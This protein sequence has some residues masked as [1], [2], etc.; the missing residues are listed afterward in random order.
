M[1]G[2]V[3]KCSNIYPDKSGEAL[4]SPVEYESIWALGVK[5]SSAIKEER[6]HNPFCQRLTDFKEFYCLKENWLSYRE[7]HGIV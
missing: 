5:P 7:Q 1:P 3:I 4:C 6:E 2:C